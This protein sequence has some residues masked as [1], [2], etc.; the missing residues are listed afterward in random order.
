MT[1]D[2]TNSILEQE[3]E[4]LGKELDELKAI[5]TRPMVVNVEQNTS[6]AMNQILTYLPQLT[7]IST[8]L[9][10][11]ASTVSAMNSSMVAALDRL[12]KTLEARLP[13]IPEPEEDA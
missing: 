1:D 3:N 9:S 6:P 12:T 2:L 4:R 7:H 5:L 13:L 11:V 8:N 10:H